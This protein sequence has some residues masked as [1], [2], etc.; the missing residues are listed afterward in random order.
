MASLLSNPWLNIGQGLLAN[1]GPSLTPV[2]PWLGIGQGLMN[3]NAAQVAEQENAYRQQQMA[4]EQ[5]KLEQ[6][7]RQQQ[8]IQDLASQETDPQL[9]AYARIDPEGYAKR[10]FAG[11]AGAE[12]TTAGALGLPNLPPELPIQVKKDENGNVTGY[13]PITIPNAPQAPSDIREYEYAQK[14]GYKGSFTDYQGEMARA[15]AAQVN[16]GD[17]PVSITD[18]QHLQMPDGSSPPPGISLNDAVASGAVV[19][20]TKTT[21]SQN[22]AAGFYDRMQN[23]S[24]IIDEVAGAGYNPATLKHKYTPNM[25]APADTQKYRQAQKDWVRAKLRKES[26]ATIGDQEMQDEIETYFP[27][28]GDTEEV[29]TQKKHARMI[30]ERAML[31]QSGAKDKPASGNESDQSTSHPANA[32]SLFDKYPGLTKA[33]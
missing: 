9:A 6:Q 26:G 29:M 12:L 19:R 25:L 14:Q 8:Y 20:P 21:D 7:Q 24:A 27:Q 30:A 3:A 22:L 11:H 4:M 17:K 28:P 33:P 1:S 5:Q 16:I 13:D 15:G 32:A 31:K 23:S 10:K 2:N 18:L